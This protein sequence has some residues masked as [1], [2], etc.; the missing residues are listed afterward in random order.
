MVG[1]EFWMQFKRPVFADETITVEWL[2]IKTEPRPRNRGLVVDLRGRIRNQLGI[3]G[4]GGEG[5]GAGR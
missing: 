4:C 1:L 3:H 5:Q 2:I